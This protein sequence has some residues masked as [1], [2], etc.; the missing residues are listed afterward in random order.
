MLDELQQVILSVSLATRELD[1]LLSLGQHDALWRRAA[2]NLDPA[3]ALELEQALVAQ[4]S[5]GTQDGVGVDPEDCCEVAGRRQPLTGERFPV[6]DRAADIAGDLVVQERR[7]GAV[8]LDSQHSASHYNTNDSYAA[9]DLMA[10]LADDTVARAERLEAGPPISTELGG[11]LLI[12]E[13]RR[14]QRRRRLVVIVSL[15]ALAVSYVMLH[16]TT[17]PRRSASLL[18]RPLHFPSLAPNG[19]CPVSSGSTVDNSSFVG[20]ALGS[21]PV[22]VLLA[23]RGDILRGRVDLGSSQAPGWSALQTLWFAAPGYDGP[24]VVRAARLGTRG[25]IEV[26][27]DQT[28]LGPG[29]G[30]LLVATGPTANTQDGYRTIPGSTWVRSPGCYAWQVDGHGFSEIIVANTFAAAQEPPRDA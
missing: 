2:G 16:S 30:A 21:G 25:P 28:G 15:A 26:K 27:A 20:V 13:A 29:R 10:L 6:G 18:S 7:V 8:H 23:D 12:R 3:A 22:R 11:E 5:Q 17:S 4:H 14:R 19:A 1:E 24:F 9:D